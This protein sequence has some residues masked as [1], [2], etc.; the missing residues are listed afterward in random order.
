MLHSYTQYTYYFY[1]ILLHYKLICWGS[2]ACGAGINASIVNKIAL[3]IKKICILSCCMIVYTIL[4]GVVPCES[5]ITFQQ[6]DM[7][8][9]HKH[10][11]FVSYNIRAIYLLVLFRLIVITYLCFYLVHPLSNLH[12]LCVAQNKLSCKHHKFRSI[13]WSI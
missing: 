4:C 9:M 3:K 5:G 13:I 1:M 7:S 6:N 11:S 12:N 2:P 8:G 10:Q